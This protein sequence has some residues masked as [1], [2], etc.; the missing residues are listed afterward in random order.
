VILED[1]GTA[2]LRD[3]TEGS[4]EEIDPANL[5]ERIAALRGD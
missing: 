1:D 3:L 2:K 5:P 4:Q